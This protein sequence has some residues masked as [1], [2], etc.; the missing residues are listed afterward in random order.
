MTGP[1]RTVL[2]ARAPFLQLLD[3]I[4]TGH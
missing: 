1:S 4:R 3:S 2:A